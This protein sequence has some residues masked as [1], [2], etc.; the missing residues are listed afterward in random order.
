MALVD[1]GVAEA[2]ADVDRMWK[3]IAELRRSGR[4]TRYAEETLAGL[5]VTHSVCEAR[6]EIIL[7]ELEQ[8][9]EQV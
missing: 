4:D 7:I 6:R 8:V 1:R 5:L 9:S 2:H 3:R